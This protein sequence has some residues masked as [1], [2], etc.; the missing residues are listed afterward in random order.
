MKKTGSSVGGHI[1]DVTPNVVVVV[2][3]DI[4]NTQ[5]KAIK[6]ELTR[7]ATFGEQRPLIG[8]TLIGP[9][10]LTFKASYL[11]TLGAGDG[12]RSASSSCSSAACCLEETYLPL[13]SNSLACNF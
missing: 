3:V 9:N 2:V 6:L 8:R 12:R 7:D 5:A 11:H 4:D 10:E 13:S 1:A